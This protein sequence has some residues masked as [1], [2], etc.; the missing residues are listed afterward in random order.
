MMLLFVYAQLESNMNLLCACIKC[1]CFILHCDNHPYFLVLLFLLPYTH[2][3]VTSIFFSVH[4]HMIIIGF[5][6]LLLWTCTLY[7]YTEKSFKMSCYMSKLLDCVFAYKVLDLSFSTES[8]VILKKIG[9]M[10]HYLSLP[11]CFLIYI[12]RMIILRKVVGV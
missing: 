11:T 7:R 9:K 12:L 3:P 6:F 10:S 2:P 5:W 8:K 4:V 1:I